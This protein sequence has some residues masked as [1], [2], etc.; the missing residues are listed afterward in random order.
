MKLKSR[1][2]SLH[3][4]AWYLTRQSG[5]ERITNAPTTSKKLEHH[6][7]SAVALTAL[8]VGMLTCGN[9]GEQAR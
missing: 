3:V 9:V 1:M 8:L 5:I 6:Q 2:A 4:S 7:S